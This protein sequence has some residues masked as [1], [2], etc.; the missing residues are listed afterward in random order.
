MSDVLRNILE[1]QTTA[2]ILLD[3]SLNVRYVN[4]AAQ[5]LL[6]ASE[7]TCV[8][9]SIDQLCNDPSTVS[10]AFA[11][12]LKTGQTLTSRGAS[13]VLRGGDSLLVTPLMTVASFGLFGATSV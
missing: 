4:A 2:I 3:A 7:Q 8:G 9:L 10:S 13:L 1:H 11:D 12:G 5:A 6:G